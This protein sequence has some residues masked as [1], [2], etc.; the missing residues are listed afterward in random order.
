MNR[1]WRCS[2]DATATAIYRR[3]VRDAARVLRPGGWL[4]LELGWRS[5]DAVRAMMGSGWTE[6]D[7]VDDLAG[8]P[9]VIRGR[10]TP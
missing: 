1:T 10:W 9:R 3:L 2:R 7:V 4:A 5:L 6:I 8:I